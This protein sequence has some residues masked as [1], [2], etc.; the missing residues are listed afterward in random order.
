M[1]LEVETVGILEPLSPRRRNAKRKTKRRTSNKMGLKQ[2]PSEV[3]EQIFMELDPRSVNA[4]TSI[5]KSFTS[6][7]TREWVSH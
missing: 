6:I 3:L 5:S 2:M 7:G 1:S 4:V